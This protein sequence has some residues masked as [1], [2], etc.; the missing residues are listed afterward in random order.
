V[1]SRR[2]VFL[3]AAAALVALQALVLLVC[4][5]LVL[6]DLGGGLSGG[7]VQTA[8][9]FIVCAAGLAACA[10]GLYG[11][12]SWARAPVVLVQ[13]IMLGLSYDSRDDPAFSVPLAVCAVI[14][15]VCVFHPSSLRA[16][17]SED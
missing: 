9:F 16:L 13:L 10:W 15:L 2:P 11:R 12:N 7:G 1:S 8:I 5:V 4:A 14:G 17:D 6:A 3:I